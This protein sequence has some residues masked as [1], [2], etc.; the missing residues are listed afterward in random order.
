[1]A[2]LLNRGMTRNYND[3][4][5]PSRIYFNLV[6]LLSAVSL[7]ALGPTGA[8]ADT[9]NDGENDEK[10]LLPTTIEKDGGDASVCAYR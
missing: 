6:I 8:A 5:S 9:R 4:S 3:A 10:L 2:P 1:M 7:L